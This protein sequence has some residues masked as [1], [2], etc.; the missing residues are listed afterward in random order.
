MN[1]APVS[2]VLPLNMKKNLFLFTLLLITCSLNAQV[3]KVFGKITNSNLEPLSPASV[4]LQERQ[5]GTVSGQDGSYE[6]N[7]K[8]GS[9]HII[10]S[11]IGYKD[12]IVPVSLQSDLV[13]DIVLQ[14]ASQDLSEV[15]IKAKVKDRAEEVMRQLIKRKD[16]IQAAPGAYSCNV[17]IKAVQNNSNHYFQNEKSSLVNNSLKQQ[18]DNFPE[19]HDQLSGLSLEEISLQLDVDA[20]SR[21]KEKRIGVKKSGATRHLF[22]TS[23][24][25]GNFNFYDNLI[26][27]PNISPT[28]FVSPVSN[29]GL[30]A[31]KFRTKKIQRIGRHKI[32]T[33]IVTPRQMTNAT[34]EGELTISDSAWVILHARLRFPDYHLQEFDYFEVEQQFDFVNN[35]A[36]MLTQQQFTYYNKTRKNK[37]SGKTLVTYSNYQLNRDFGK[38]HFGA[39]LSATEHQAYE[40][41]SLFWQNVRTEPLTEIENKFVRYQDSLS[42]VRKSEQYLD[43]IDRLI[44]RVTWKKLGLFGQ[45]FHDHKKEQTWHL[46]PLISLYQPFA[47]GGGR[48]RG[49]LAYSRTFDSRKNIDLFGELSYGIR[50]NDV[51]GVF[52]ISRKYNPYSR[53]SYSISGGR[54]FAF[55]YEGD[56][57]INMIKRSNVYLNNYVGVG[58]GIE[59]LNGLFVT[60]DFDVAFRRPVDHYKTG[61]L[62]DSVFADVIDNNQAVSFQPYNAAYGKLQVEYTPAQHYR[63]EPKEKIIL[64]SKWPTVYAFWRKGIPGFIGSEVNFDYLE[65]GLKQQINLGLVGVSRY[66][67]KTGNFINKKDL[68]LIDFQFQRRG[69]PFLFMNPY[70]SFQAMDSTFPVFDRFFEGHLVHEFNGLFL[71][72]IPLLKRLQLREIAGGGFLMA[73]ERNL[74]Y[75]ELFV[76]VERAFQSPFN[77]LD[78]FKLGIYVVGSA[79][80]QFKNPVQFKVGFTT[81]NKRKNRWY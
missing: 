7:L 81:W 68:R 48:L 33:I 47:F 57:W 50:N 30:I 61:S 54:E 2:H 51:N 27:V 64:G 53:G 10:V 52:E 44:N 76:G 46:P 15:I 18:R 25:D 32:Y 36:W 17:Y 20:S 65:F 55:I 69:D 43:S 40:K 78:R 60:T 5:S 63:Q 22:F 38:R 73:N 66:Q 72:K 9:Y 8:A 1:F 35:K 26:K 42:I 56:A 23:A 49:S 14:D 3:Y 34:L 77:P 16:S 39:A 74:R 29:A 4:R 80:N 79:A 45:S 75:A 62:A 37:L 19:K 24:T 12:I 31:Y 13:Q 71:N 58:H 21:M 67:V 41:D 59:L 6:M 28:P 70:K 11:M